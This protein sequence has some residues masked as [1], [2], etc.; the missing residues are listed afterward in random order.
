MSSGSCQI[1]NRGKISKNTRS[2]QH[3]FVKRPYRTPL[4]MVLN[5]CM[6]SGGSTL[7]PVEFGAEGGGEVRS[8]AT[9]GCEAEVALFY[10]ERGSA[11]EPE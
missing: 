3:N 5:I 1:I 7:T 10:C 2:V 8:G 9:E 6:P 11:G 4:Y